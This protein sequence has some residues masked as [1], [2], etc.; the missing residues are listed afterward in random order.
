MTYALIVTFLT[1]LFVSLAGAFIAAQ[2][3][4]PGWW[5][6]IV[7]VVAAVAQGLLA[8]YKHQTEPPA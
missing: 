5:W 6:L 3:Q 2:A 7:S 1:A 8:L 4:F